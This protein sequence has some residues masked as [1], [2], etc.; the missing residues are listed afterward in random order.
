MEL[1]QR[2]RRFTTDELQS[3]ASNLQSKKSPGPDG[4]PAEV[5]KV[6]KESNIVSSF[7]DSLVEADRPTSYYPLSCNGLPAPGTAAV[8]NRNRSTSG[9]RKMAGGSSSVGFRWSSYFVIGTWSD[10]DTIVDDCWYWVA[11]SGGEIG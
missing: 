4:V 3:A 9:S 2:Y 6:I 8:G 1:P 5:L 7:K 11:S 10:V